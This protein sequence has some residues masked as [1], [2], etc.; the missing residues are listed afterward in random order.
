MLKK[1]LIR[2]YYLQSVS[3]PL[4]SLLE[5]KNDIAIS[6]CDI[7]RVSTQKVVQKQLLS[8]LKTLAPISNIKILIATGGF[9]RPNTKEELIE[10][11]T[12]L[13]KCH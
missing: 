8:T 13:I 11:V 6:A 4:R 5:G 7:T 3:K 12:L 2:H 10:E 1:K 9:H